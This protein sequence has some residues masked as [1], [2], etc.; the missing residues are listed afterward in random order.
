MIPNHNQI[1][2]IL[3]HTF[4]KQKTL[5]KNEGI[6]ILSKIFNMSETDLVK[7]TRKEYGYSFAV[8]VKWQYRNLEDMG[9]IKKS[10]QKYIITKTG[11][12]VC[13][14]LEYQIPKK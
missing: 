5:T 3:L 6:E 4:S 9:F 1:R 7:K 11:L 13:R 12:N 2:H 10:G 8:K 14:L